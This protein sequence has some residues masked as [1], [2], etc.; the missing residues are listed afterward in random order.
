LSPE[1]GV[2]AEKEGLS[3]SHA[4]SSAVES[5]GIDYRMDFRFTA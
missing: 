4:P 3:L 5:A 1:V 2:D